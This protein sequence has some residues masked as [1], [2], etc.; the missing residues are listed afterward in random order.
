MGAHSEGDEAAL[1]TI[2]SIM[3]AAPRH[4]FIDQVGGRGRR[5]PV[6]ARQKQ[7]L[8]VFEATIVHGDDSCDGRLGKGT[9]MGMQ[10]SAEGEAGR[11]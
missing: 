9:A 11:V 4:R 10:D 1:L 8:F 6:T 2:F 3:N 7:G 5:Q